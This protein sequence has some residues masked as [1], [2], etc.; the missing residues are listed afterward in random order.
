MAT[1]DLTRFVIQAKGQYGKW[2]KKPLAYR[3]S[4]NFYLP[5]THPPEI[6]VN[7]VLNIFTLL[8]VMQFLDNL[9]HSFIVFTVTVNR[10]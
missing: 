10:E 8:T 4:N 6:C 9:F 5:V 1:D 3:E 7:P 2:T